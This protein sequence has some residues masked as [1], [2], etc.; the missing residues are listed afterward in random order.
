MLYKKILYTM[1]LLLAIYLAAEAL[2]FGAYYIA[3]EK[4]FSFADMAAR[5][6]TVL[7]S[8]K[9]SEETK[10]TSPQGTV[11]HPY[12]G[13]VYDPT[14][15]KNPLM[16]P[17]GF[18]AERDPIVA[19]KEADTAI[20]AITGG[21]TAEQF[22]GSAHGVLHSSLEKMPQFQ[23]KKIDIIM[24]GRGMYHQ[25]QL[26]TSVAYYL[27]QGGR[28]DMLINLDGFNEITGPTEEQADGIYPAYPFAW[29][30]IF[31]GQANAPSPSKLADVL[32]WKHLRLL[33]LDVFAPWN[34]SITAS[35]VW[36]R[37]DH[38]CDEKTV[39]A[40]G[41][42]YSNDNKKLPY[43]ITG[44]DTLNHLSTKET[45]AFGVQLWEQGSI[46]LNA[47]AKAYHFDYFH[48]LQPNQYAAGSKPLSDEEKQHAYEPQNPRYS[49]I[50]DAYPLLEA[51]VERLRARGEA[52]Y[53]LTGIFKNE[54]RTVYLDVCCHI[55]PVGNEI[56]ANA[57][58]QQITA[59]YVR[60]GVAH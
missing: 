34:F 40:E 9:S 45:V 1:G 52:A 48:F 21:S 57:I 43:F 32:M 29:A 25:P 55:N 12:L 28:L 27:M 53:S 22:F 26:V 3:E 49:Y 20:V 18:L 38:Y 39:L 37:I 35:T 41:A 2:S 23:G 30:E 11:P 8:L 17:Y 19:S 46:Q 36:S 60:R 6:M 51:G 58:V 7:A 24:L 10:E 14:V 50:T 16:T 56:M 5:R 59:D 47:I 13:F 31:S 54:P 4:L 42:L 44:P 15:E 33:A